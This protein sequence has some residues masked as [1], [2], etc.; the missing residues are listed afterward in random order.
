M[1]SNFYQYALIIAGVAVTLLFGVFLHR[2]LFPEYKIYQEDYVALEE[3]R[4]TYTHE[5]APAF[6]YGIKQ[7]V[8]ERADKGPPT[9][10]RCTSCHVALE[11]GHFSPTKIA[12]DVNGRMELDANGI[13]RQIPNENYV[14][15]RLDAKIAELPEGSAEK[16][17]AL[18]TAKVGEHTYDVTKVL[19]M[20]PLIG[21][22][23]RPFEFHPL[24]QYGC[25]SCH[26]GNGR[27]LV[28]DRAHGPVFDGQ[29]EIEFLGPTPKFT[30]VD[31][32]NDPPFA[33]MFN[34]KPG[35]RLLFVTT[36]IL[37][38]GLI[39]SKCME[40]HLEGSLNEPSLKK[41]QIAEK[42]S[43]E[44]QEA[45]A[46]LQKLKKSIETQGYEKTLQSLQKETQDYT[47]PPKKRSEIQAQ[48][49]FLTQIGAAKA[50]EEIEK[51][52]NRKLTSDREQLTP[53]FKQ[54][55]EL[56][57]SQACYACHRIAG[58]ARG[59][60]GPEL[61]R[62]GNAYPWFIKESIVW[63]Q[64][65]V[66]TSTMPNYRF[67]HQELENLMTFLL[68]QKGQP[69][70][71]SDTAY[72][73]KIQQ[74]EAG[75]KMPWEEPLTPVQMHDVRFAMTLFAT[76]GCAACHR[77]KG[78]ESDVGFAIE[79]E[80][81]DFD[82]LYEEREWFKRLIPEMIVG[83]E[84]VKALEAHADE[85]D[86]HIVAD[87]RK[88]SIIEEIEKKFPDQI[89]ALYMPFR[90]ASRA[91][92]GDKIWQERLYRVL[93]VFIQE[94]GL[95]RLIGPRPNW[96][97]IYRSDE[98]LMEHFH[99]PSAHV[100][101]SIM[102]VFPFDDTKFY[103]L[104]Y[105]LDMLAKKNRDAVH[106]VW[107]KRGFSPE[108]AY[109][110]HC[111]QCHGEFL[112]GNGPVSEWIYPIPKNLR[113]ADFLR[114]LTKERVISSIAHGVK[115][116]PMPPWGEAAVDKPFEGHIPVLTA[117][118]TQQLADWLF[119]GVPG[120]E[121]IKSSKDVPK[122]RYMPQDVLKELREE[123]NELKSGPPLTSQPS[124]KN[125]SQGPLFASLHPEI[126]A[127]EPV[128]EVFDIVPN[129]LP[130]QPDPLLYY[131]K[132]EYYTSEN[133]EQGRAFFEINC[134]VCHG[135]EADGSG[136][137]ASAMR[138]AK[139]RM[140]TNLDWI[141]TRDDLRLLRSIK[142]GVPGTA[143]N[144]WGD[145][146][147]SLQ[148]M[149]LVMFIRSLSADHHL[150]ET[151]SEALYKTYAHE[152]RVVDNA[153][154]HFYPVLDKL[155]KDYAELQTRRR[156]LD[157]KADK[158]AVEVYQKELET[159]AERRNQEATDQILQ[160]LMNEIEREKNLYQGV[161]QQIITQEKSD[162]A[163]APLLDII[164]A[165]G[166]RYSFKE[167]KLTGRFDEENKVAGFGKTLSDNFQKEIDS[168][169]H[170]LI[171]V[172]GKIASNERS[173]EVARLNADIHALVSLRGET[174]S[175]LE[176]AR[177]SRTK[178]KLLLQEFQE[179]VKQ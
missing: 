125:E 138:D 144:P 26:G 24:E 121:V 174:L 70:S 82:K 5:P 158:E 92:N 36:P 33:R 129:P 4:S 155:D 30:E 143:M 58:F 167:G 1:A 60:V 34:D 28:T 11:F 20:H 166:N 165:N 130:E 84:L 148:R 29:Y 140:L 131:I 102:P 32:K 49:N 48:I 141:N 39:E 53:H 19:Q 132:K 47:L 23:T 38:G 110:I 37:M 156:L 18:K 119:A 14:W 152:M 164:A 115:G 42:A 87:V 99:N 69:K 128:D 135:T 21:R 108:Q 116:T 72:Q 93:M 118:E 62:E 50:S 147:S 3:F 126:E 59:G 176:E 160:D 134:A 88:G 109:E 63:P 31:P 124:G 57:I 172:Q 142:Y 52:L 162:E 136:M 80:K 12:Y 163:L 100:A 178:Q 65:D 51:Q 127:S 179:K 6:N 66:P 17:R 9:I 123:G 40:C 105:M 85:I 45:D 122:W 95:G 16:Y 175:T 78:F 149:Q 43:R 54:G 139:P 157:E 112:Q 169:S 154:I 97:G 44:A 101:R 81:P 2:E 35:D 171:L 96:S 8:I 153:R 64:A 86:T 111:S 145:L 106:L 22:E 146:T 25:V 117:A 94:Y 13:P 173:A 27:G 168:L 120:A 46:T 114:N 61:T 55:E 41:E 71:I 7:I 83:S 103:A 177:R 170:E 79:K 91:K 113:N 104:T 73:I 150:R 151:L 107:E 68:A 75:K 77:L 15:A 133:L 56:Y 89:E 137:R 10:D 159:L 90:Y 98:W 76:Q 161:G 74:W 67:D